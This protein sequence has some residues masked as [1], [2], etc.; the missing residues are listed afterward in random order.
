[1]AEQVDIAADLVVGLLIMRADEKVQHRAENSA[2]HGHRDDASGIADGQ[3]HG[4]VFAHEDAHLDAGP[5][6][7][8]RPLRFGDAKETLRPKQDVATREQQRHPSPEVSKRVGGALHTGIITGRR[9]QRVI[10]KACGN[11]EEVNERAN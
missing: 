4:K 6:N 9:R 8:L 11:I 1:M 5:E 3:R 7:D 2:D 10:Q